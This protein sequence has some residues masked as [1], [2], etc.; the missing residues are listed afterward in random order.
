MVASSPQDPL[1]A[2]DDMDMSAADGTAAQDILDAQR[3]CEALRQEVQLVHGF[4]LHPSN[5]AACSAQCPE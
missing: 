5:Y 1:G 2:D 4:T 3:L